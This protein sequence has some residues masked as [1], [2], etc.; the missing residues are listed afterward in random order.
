MPVKKSKPRTATTERRIKKYKETWRS[1]T[2][3]LW[4]KK[5]APKMAGLLEDWLTNQDELEKQIFA[6]L[7]ADGISGEQQL[8]YAAFA[9]RLF[10]TCLRFYDETYEKEKTSLKNEFVLRGL[11]PSELETIIDI[12]DDKC[13]VVRGIV[14]TLQ[15]I[16]DKLDNATWGLAALKALIDDL[17]AKLDDGTHGLA[18]LKTLIDAVEGKLDNGTYGLSALKTL[19]DAIEAKLDNV[20]YG[21]SALNNDLDTL[22]LR[23]TAARAGYLD[24]LNVGGLVASSA[25]VDEVESMLKDVNYGLSALNTDLDTLLSRLTA[26]RASYLDNLNIGENV[27]ASSQVDEVESLLKNG[28]YGLAALDTHLDAIIVYVD[29]VESLLKNATFGLAALNTDLDTLLSRLTAARAGFLDNIDNPQLK[30]VPNLTGLTPLRQTYLDY[31]PLMMHCMT[32]LSIINA[33][34]NLPAAAADTNLP[35]VVIS[36]LPVGF[37]LDKVLVFLIVRAIE[38][39]NAGGPNAIEGAQNIRIKK[40]TGAWGVDDIIAIPLTDNMWTVAAST[41]EFGDVIGG[42]DAH[43]VKSEVDGNAT[44]NLRFEDANVDLDFLRLNDVQVVIK[45]WYH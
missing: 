29:E 10:S 40:S 32:F 20:T 42:D 7:D 43:D 2:V 24:N 25:Q 28:T 21:L 15:D 36:G 37:T 23:L 22:L 8:F 13:K 5:V 14:V 4:F 38:N 41:R 30:V 31:L 35:D 17:E 33:Q 16:E 27:A 39:T 6:Q 9:R 18:A 26:L 3:P 1:K 11:D 12:C 19:I 44:Y 45:V 34:I